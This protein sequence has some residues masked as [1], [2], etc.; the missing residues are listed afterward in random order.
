MSVVQL[1]STRL[2]WNSTVGH[3]A[4]NSVMSCNR[5]E[6]TKRFLHFNNNENLIESLFNIRLYLEQIRSR[7]LQ[8]P[9]EEFLAVDEQIIPTKARTDLKQYNSKKPHKWGYKNFALSGISGFSYDF[10]LYAESQSNSIPP[11][12]PDLV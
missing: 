7:L 12:A 2:C 11:G 5:F 6:Q 4:V 10:D 1:P 9:K 8:V 3:P